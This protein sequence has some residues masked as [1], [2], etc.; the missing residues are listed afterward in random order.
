MR[1]PSLGPPIPSDLIPNEA[2]DPDAGPAFKRQP[3][4]RRPKLGE[5]LLDMGAISGS[6]LAR[7]LMLQRRL[8]ARLGDVLIRRNL[9]DEETLAVALGRQRGMGRAGNPPLSTPNTDKLA[10]K[11]PLELALKYH[12]LPWRRVGGKTLIATSRPELVDEL[13]AA[14]PESMGVCLF[15]VA[16]ASALEA[17]MHEV[18]G[19]TL[20]RAAECRVPQAISCR[21]W[22][23]RTGS[24]ALAIFM[25]TALIATALWP[26]N[27][28]QV[29]TAAALL[30]MALNLGLR[31]AAA[32]ALFRTPKGFASIRPA[33]EAARRL[34]CIS[35]LVP[36]HREPSIAG[37]LTER[38]SRLDY[39]RELLDIC[40]VVEADD[41]QTLDA[42]ERSNLPRWMRV[43]PVPDG[44][45]RTK[46]RA[47][48]YALNFA[49]GS[50]V[51]I[52]DAEDAPAPDQLLT[53][54]TRFRT[55]PAN[56]ACLQGRLDYYNPMR[57][58]MSRCFT[59]EYAN[60][61][62]L[63]LPGIARLGLVVPLGGTTL[64]F[65][66]RAI[67]TVGG[68]DAHNVT[69]DADLG[70]RLAR[71]G[72]RTE[73]ID[74]TTLEEANASPIAWV[75]QRSRWMKGYILTWAVHSRRPRELWQDLGTRRFLGF[76][77]LFMG[78]ILNALLTP[79]LWSTTVVAFG[80]HHPI[81]DWFPGNGAMSLG[82]FLGLAL[83]LSMGLA[84]IGCRAPHHRH[85]RKWIPT[86]E[87][88]F[89][90]AT[91]AVIKALAEIVFKPFHWDKTSHGAFGGTF[92]GGIS[93]LELQLSQANDAP[94]SR[95]SHGG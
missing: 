59:I 12:A 82:I 64:F 72:F 10:R 49:R 41:R 40:L 19:A 76:H 92:Q 90:L 9:V 79:V 29:A 20:A 75:K 54:A 36:L 89:P 6:D 7:A 57:N 56:V 71:M 81:L 95:V 34:P 43:I 93:E 45:P 37:P 67:E 55:A 33:E 83:A 31:V 15:A 24:A 39:P 23:P 68:W 60:W 65:R 30:V 22:Q 44:R 4:I 47:M 3:Y 14:L 50:I 27:A 84:C 17:R 18:H 48:N 46:P 8:S 62:R 87:L 35:I 66:R 52:Y 38:L 85:L 80:F 13:R 2:A 51:G 32:I 86:L 5:V 74:T 21:S 1:F 11:L 63:V 94:K 78:A 73:I 61:F 70:V 69:E 91:L 42:L 25:L 28:L 16:T 88:Y 53:V 58:W 77:L 26:Y